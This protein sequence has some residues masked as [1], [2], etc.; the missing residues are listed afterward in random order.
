MK[1]TSSRLLW[2]SMAEARDP[3]KSNCLYKFISSNFFFALAVCPLLSLIGW[4]GWINFI[5]IAKL[6]Y[7]TSHHSVEW[8]WLE[9]EIISETLSSV[10]Y[11]CAHSV[12]CARR[13]KTV[14]AFSLHSISTSS[15][16]AH[17][18][19]HLAYMQHPTTMCALSH[20]TFPSSGCSDKTSHKS[21]E[22]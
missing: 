14:P 5:S 10:L 4:M 3:D 20:L 8:C 18:Q 11:N 13:H 21:F 12:Q 16:K 19:H 1:A 7:I 6:H 17:H 2:V 9:F 15:S 22:L